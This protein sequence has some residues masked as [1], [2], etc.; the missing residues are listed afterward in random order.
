MAGEMTVL[1]ETG[2][3]SETHL[4]FNDI[5][6]DDPSNPSLMKVQL[7][8]SKTDPCRKGINIYVGSTGNNLCPIAAILAYLAV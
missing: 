8:A 1:S 7:K 2:Y 5:A 3:D 6:T 4:G